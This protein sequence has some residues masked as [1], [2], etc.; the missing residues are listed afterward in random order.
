MPLLSVYDISYSASGDEVGGRRTRQ[1][2]RSALEK[3]F[4]ATN[5]L[6]EGGMQL[7]SHLEGETEAAG[8]LLES[9]D[10]PHDISALNVIE[11]RPPQITC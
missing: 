3:V 6:P 1:T 4:S 5:P 9:L 11:V 7:L 10:A 2:A 8:A